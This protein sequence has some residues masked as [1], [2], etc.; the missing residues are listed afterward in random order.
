MWSEK[1][2][3]YFFPSVELHWQLNFHSCNPGNMFNWIKNCSRS[4][5]STIL[6]TLSPI[7]MVKWKNVR[8]CAKGIIVFGETLFF[9]SV[10][11]G[12]RV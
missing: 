9:T 4:P 7:V 10:I 11:V 8:Y 1:E 2:L 6:T 5:N 3:M 12:E